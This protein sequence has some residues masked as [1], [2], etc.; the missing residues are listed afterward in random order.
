MGLPELPGPTGRSSSSRMPLARGSNPFS[1]ILDGQAS[2]HV[3]GIKMARKPLLY[4][5]SSAMID[6]MV[7][8][9]TEG[10]GLL[11]RLPGLHDF[12]ELIIAALTNILVQSESILAGNPRL[13]DQDLLERQDWLDLY[14]SRKEMQHLMPLILEQLK[15]DGREPP[16]PASQYDPVDSMLCLRARLFHYHQAEKPTFDAPGI[17]CHWISDSLHD[18]RSTLG[19]QTTYAVDQ[20]V[21]PH[22]AVEGEASQPAQQSGV[23]AAAEAQLEAAIGSGQAPGLQL[24]IR[25]AVRTLAAADQR[26]TSLDLEELREFGLPSQR[27]VAYLEAWFMHQFKSHPRSKDDFERQDLCAHREW[28]DLYLKGYEGIKHLVLQQLPKY[29]VKP[30]SKHDSAASFLALRACLF[31]YQHPRDPVNVVGLNTFVTP[32]AKVFGISKPVPQLAAVTSLL[33]C[34]F[35]SAS[36]P[37]P[38]TDVLV[39]MA[40][41]LIF[42]HANRQ[43]LSGQELQLICSDSHGVAPDAPTGSPCS[44]TSPAAGPVQSRS[45]TSAASAQS[46]LHEPASASSAQAQRPQRPHS[47]ASFR[48]EKNV[49]LSISG[50]NCSDC[51]DILTASMAKALNGRGLG[52]HFSNDVNDEGKH[53]STMLPACNNIE[54]D[55]YTP[56]QCQG[57]CEALIDAHLNNDV[58]HSKELTRGGPPAFKVA[59]DPSASTSSAASS[60]ATA[61]PGANPGRSG[62]SGSGLR[63][64]YLDQPNSKVPGSMPAAAHVQTSNNR[65]DDSGPITTAGLLKAAEEWYKQLQAA[66]SSR[67]SNVDAEA[68][69]SSRLKGRDGIQTSAQGGS[70][71]Q[72]SAED[73]AAAEKRAEE[74]A[75]DLLREVEQEE[76]ARQSKKM[77]SKARKTSKTARPKK[78]SASAQPVPTPALTESEAQPQGT[79]ERGPGASASSISARQEEQSGITGAEHQ[80]EAALQTGQ[81]A[82]LQQ[83]IRYAVRSIAAADPHVSLALRSNQLDT[84]IEDDTMHGIAHIAP[85]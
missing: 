14:L 45:Q 34:N 25:F 67:S 53:T 7:S 32:P 73:K 70:A 26:S 84:Q 1:N 4:Y 48:P 41:R 5:G 83:A 17:N 82:H 18:G 29:D 85:A 19:H 81:A 50:C 3:E 57:W 54:H 78:A 49:T 2:S 40:Q 22:Q 47:N 38:S 31:R 66:S 44:E 6:A 39:A 46:R 8:G 21:H 72:P 77:K 30:A 76:K 20:A 10:Q 27:P 24:A 36:W 52:A 42:M 9:Q 63:R 16:A 43:L 79:S 12:P 62:T 28:L 11:A 60:A 55:W 33:T 71:G 74:A 37:C 59:D 65:Q 61:Q 56:E 64:A 58:A 13:Y 75:A 69:Q 80:L 23:L 51:R 15:M 68:R 35:T